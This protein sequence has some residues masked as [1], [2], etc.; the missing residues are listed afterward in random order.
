MLI[1][2][3]MPF[4]CTHQ[5]SILHSSHLNKTKQTYNAL[6]APS[7]RYSNLFRRNCQSR[8]APTK[9]FQDQNNTFPPAPASQV[10]HMAASHVSMVREPLSLRKC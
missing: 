1:L 8:G 3:H 2:C 9:S 7:G 10:R 5:E 6:V 4:H